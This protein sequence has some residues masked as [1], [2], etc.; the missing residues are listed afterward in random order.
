MLYQPKGVRVVM[1]KLENPNRIADTVCGKQQSYTTHKNTNFRYR[2]DSGE[3]VAYYN[4]NSIRF[5]RLIELLPTTAPLLDFHFNWWAS[6][7]LIL[8]K[9]AEAILIE[10]RRRRAATVNE[11]IRSMDDCCMFIVVWHAL[12]DCCIRNVWNVSSENTSV[13]PSIM[14]LC[15]FIDNPEVNEINSTVNSEASIA[16][17]ITY[18]RTS[19]RNERML[20]FG[21]HAW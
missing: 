18:W 16:F 10:Y 21:K 12:R 7:F 3:F 4:E 2:D 11:Q 19:S 13:N 5:L 1:M 20:S 17:I 8:Q 9:K 6:L 15:K 14:N